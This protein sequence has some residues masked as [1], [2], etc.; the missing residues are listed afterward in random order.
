[1]Q[2]RVVY[3]GWEKVSC[4]ERCRSLLIETRERFHCTDTHIDINS[5]TVVLYSEFVRGL[6][7]GGRA[8]ELS[9]IS[10]FLSLPRSPEGGRRRER[11]GRRNV[12]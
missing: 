3:L 10:L 6:V 5:A 7:S 8:E 4:L 12:E 1:M 2:A 9:Q 11:G